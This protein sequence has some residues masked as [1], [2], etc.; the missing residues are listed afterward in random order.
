MSQLIK[1]FIGNDQVDGTKIHL[2]N[3]QAIRARNAADSA[4][5]NILKLDA[6][7]IVQVTGALTASGA[8][9]GSNLSGTNSGD[10]TLAAV[11]STPSTNGASLS[12]QVLT[13][14]P[15]D[16][17]NPGLLSTSAQSIAGVKTFSVAPVSSA[18]AVSSNE[19]V[20]F[21]QLSA[22]TFVNNKELFVLSGTNITNQYV[23]LAHVAKT[24][25]IYLAVKGAGA[26]IEG[27]SYDYS[28]SYT[29]GSGGNTRVTFLNELA[30]GGASALIAGDVVVFQY[31]Y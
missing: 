8:V 26:I 29:G 20:R 24:N 31:Q 25:S 27:A 23:D 30:T 9:S 5:I 11:G 3:N 6:S 14:Q 19:L 28:V 10:V 7:N 2:D 17:T 22:L 1:K 16:A 13:L 15:A 18:D 12:G 4:D 21:S